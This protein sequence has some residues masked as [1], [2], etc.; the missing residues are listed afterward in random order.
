MD[1]VIVYRS[2]ILP[3][4]ETF[5]LAQVR[6][7]RRFEPHLIGIRPVTGLAL[8]GLPVELLE[9]GQ[10]RELAFRYAGYSPRLVKVGRKCG[11]ALIHAH[12]AIDG[13]EC[14]PLAE[15]L[16]LPL[17]VTLHGYDVTTTDEAFLE[18]R[19]GHRFLARRARLQK[20]AALF[21]CVSN[22]I[23]EQA[24]ERGFPPEKLVVH[25]L[26]IDAAKL[27]PEAGQGREPVVLLVGRLAEKKG[28]DDLLRAMA[29]ARANCPAAKLV[30]IGDGPLRA[31]LEAEAAEL[32]LPCEF[33]G[34]QP[35]EVVHH[36]MR[37]SQVLAVPGA[38]AYSSDCEGLGTVLCEALALGLAAVGFA[39]GAFPDFVAE[40]CGLSA[41]EGDVGG[42]ASQ[43][44]LALANDNLRT[45]LTAQ[46]RR[47]VARNFDLARQTEKLE[48][49]YEYI[50]RKTVEVGQTSPW[51]GLKKDAAVTSSRRSTV[52]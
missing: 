16:N 52:L 49:I 26:G 43:L 28:L 10:I 44:T 12:F 17:L 36:W 48:E 3:A 22:F 39:S 34:A 27:V 29:A 21:L 50:T 45:R 18:T 20:K 33:L 38:R 30:V 5:I 4:A 6:A 15:K 25:H 35:H 14:L 13:A 24:I 46:A 40:G 2:E 47:H 41:K 1:R 37:R 9:G 31:Q 8:D 19:R 11:A 23:R 7:L 42:L 51:S 32:G